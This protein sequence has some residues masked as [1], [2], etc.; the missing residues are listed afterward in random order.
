M[1]KNYL[2]KIFCIIIHFYILQNIFSLENNFDEEYI[3]KFLESQLFEIQDYQNQIFQEKIYSEKYNQLKNKWMPNF[4]IS[5]GTGYSY[6]SDYQIKNPHEFYYSNKLNFSQKLPLGISFD[7]ELFSFSGN[8]DKDK[9]LHTFDYLGSLQFAVPVMSYMFG[10]A[11]DLIF[12]EKNE[13]QNYLN[14]T[15]IGSKITKKQ[16]ANFLKENIGRYLYNFELVNFYSAK[17]KVLTEKQNDIE[18]MFLEGQLSF[19]EL[20]NVKN[21]ILQ[22]SDLYNNS[23]YELNQIVTLLENSGCDVSQIKFDL[24]DW[25]LYCSKNENS[26]CD[27]FINY[28]YQ[29]YQLQSQ[30]INNVKS[31]NQSFPNLYISF[32]TIPTGT[33]RNYFEENLSSLESF[34]YYWSTVDSCQINLSLSMKINLMSYDDVFVNKKILEVEKQLFEQNLSLLSK[35]R[36]EETQRRNKNYQYYFSLY[37]NAKIIYFQEKEIFASHEKMYQNSLISKYYY[38]SSKFYLQQLYFD[39]IEKYL[40]YYKF[41]LSCF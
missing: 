38:L 5:T 40:N 22:N 25:I 2:I 10:F 6:D 24:Q 30:W 11:D 3:S 41:L 19:S 14:Y 28:D 8:L 31:Y 32:S 20:I 33:K 21:E 13:T 9:I 17:E 12:I 23:I 29:F 1:S 4:Y 34:S 26:I 7:A 18:K 16:I 15:T 37:E 27:D 36:V 39:Y 35:K